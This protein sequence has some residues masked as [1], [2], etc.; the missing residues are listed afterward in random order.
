MV[1]EQWAGPGSSPE[2]VLKSDDKYRVFISDPAHPHYGESGIFTGEVIEFKYWKGRMAKVDLSNCV[3]GVDSC[4]V[5]PG[6]IS[7]LRKGRAHG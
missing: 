2:I 3:H 6:Q 5:S 1:R 4:F 7:T